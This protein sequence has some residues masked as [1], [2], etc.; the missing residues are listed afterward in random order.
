MR[1]VRKH[2]S[3]MRTHTHIHTFAQ[4]SN[5][6]ISHTQSPTLLY[7]VSRSI[8]SNLVC[9]GVEM[10]RESNTF[11]FAA[12]LPCFSSASLN[13]VH[14]QLFEVTCFRMSAPQCQV[15]C[16]WTLSRIRKCRISLEPEPCLPLPL[17]PLPPLQCLMGMSRWQQYLSAH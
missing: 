10:V 12:V 1:K 16:R 4:K 2:E 9:A 8:L 5:N 14:G 7:L 3:Q 15:T 13:A 11:T 6:F 17:L